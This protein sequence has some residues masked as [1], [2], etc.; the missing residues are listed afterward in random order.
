MNG[1]L[2]NPIRLAALVVS[3]AI[4]CACAEQATPGDMPPRDMAPS[5][6]TGPYGAQTGDTLD[7]VMMA[8]YRLSPNA[9]DST[10]LMW[11]TAIRLGDFHASTACTCLVIAFHA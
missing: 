5:Y 8:G 2:K 10:R 4:L 1:D 11:D 7:D 9:R 3:G 6:P